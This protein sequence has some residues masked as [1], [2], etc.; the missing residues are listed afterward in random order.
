MAEIFGWT[1]SAIAIV[2]AV[3]TARRQRVGFIFY[4]V[5]NIA[6]ISVG[7]MKT[8]LYNVLLFSVFLFAAWYGYVNWG[9]I[10][11]K[12]NKQPG[13]THGEG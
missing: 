1:G 11:R 3:L 5:S 9:N 7:F 13:D 6:L 2:G 8:E 4:I 12:E 10:E